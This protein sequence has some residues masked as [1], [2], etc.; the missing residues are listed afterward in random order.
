VPQD[1]SLMRSLTVEECIRCA[2]FTSM[3]S[4]FIEYFRRVVDVDREG[5]LG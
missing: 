3:K 2:V 5:L 1:D 4:C